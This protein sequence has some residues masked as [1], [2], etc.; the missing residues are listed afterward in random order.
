MN[1]H[2]SPPIRARGR[3]PGQTPRYWTDV[4]IA[5]ITKLANQGVSIE[6][7]ASSVDRTAT[8]VGQKLRILGI[9]YHRMRERRSAETRNLT[10]LNLRMSARLVERLSDFCHDRDEYVSR[11]VEDLITGFLNQVESGSP[12]FSATA[13]GESDG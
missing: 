6:G 1:L 8:A 9:P 5:R 11:F 7:I 12:D 4:E 2:S 10:S 3:S 13:N